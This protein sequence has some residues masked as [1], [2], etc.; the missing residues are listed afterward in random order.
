MNGNI[1]SIVMSSSGTRIYFEYL[2]VCRLR[3]FAQLDIEKADGSRQVIVSDD[4]WEASLGPI[5]E[6]D[7][8]MGETY[9]A[10]R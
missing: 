6:A 10:R 2:H 9:D 4:S 3:L 1:H 8:L 5:L 7:F